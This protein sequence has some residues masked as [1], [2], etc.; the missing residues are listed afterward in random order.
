MPQQPSFSAWANA[1]TSRPSAEIVNA[2]RLAARGERYV[3]PSTAELLV[4]AGDQTGKER[5]ACLTNREFEI[6]RLLGSGRGQTAIAK[7]LGISEATAHEHIEAARK[8]YGVG[9]R[10]QLVIRALFDGQITFSDVLQ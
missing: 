3:T 5:H 10:T 9:K 1:G 4:S 2:I 6:L 8:R 7:Q